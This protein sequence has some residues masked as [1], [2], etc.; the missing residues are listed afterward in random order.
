MTDLFNVTSTH[1]G[2][3]KLFEMAQSVAPLAETVTGTV[4]VLFLLVFRRYPL[5]SSL[6]AS[7]FFTFLSALVFYLLGMLNESWLYGTGAMVAGSV[8]LAYYTKTY[9]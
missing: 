5:A 3:I 1:K 9:S 8:L 7:S 2:P 6:Q 4:F